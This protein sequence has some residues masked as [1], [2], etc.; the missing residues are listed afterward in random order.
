MVCRGCAASIRRVLGKYLKTAIFQD[1]KSPVRLR[2]RV[3]HSGRSQGHSG[4]RQPLR[5]GGP[6]L[7]QAND[8][9]RWHMAFNDIAVDF[10]GVAG[11]QPCWNLVPFLYGYHVVVK[12]LGHRKTL[13]LHML[14]PQSAAAA[15]GTLVNLGM[16]L[17]LRQSI[18]G[19]ATVC[20]QQCRNNAQQ[21]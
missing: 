9:R 14:C 6:L 11:L 5:I 19:V 15:A 17:F 10:R 8:V 12:Y 18:T 16:Q 20:S 21:Y 13:F 3:L 7:Q 1:Q 4:D 2:T